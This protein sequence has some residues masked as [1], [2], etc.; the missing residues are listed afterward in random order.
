[1]ARGSYAFGLEAGGHGERELSVTRF[2]GTEALSEP[3]L[4]EVDF[5]PVSGE[6]LDLEKLIG[7]AACLTVRC[8]DGAERPFRGI[9]SAARFLGRKKGRWQ[10]RVN[11]SPRLCMLGIASRSRTFP[12]ATVPEIAKQVL[13][14][15]KITQRWEVRGSYPKREC[16]A[17]YREPDLAFLSR[18]LEQEGIWYRFEEGEGG[19]TMVVGDGGRGFAGAGRIWY[20]QKDSAAGDEEHLYELSRRTRRVPGKVVLRD[21]DFERPM[22]DLTVTAEDGKG[23]EVYEYP[24]GYTDPGD[25]RRLAR[26]RLEE[27]RFG[28]GTWGG[29][30]EEELPDELLRDRRQ[31]CLPAAAQDRPAGGARFPASDGGGPGAGGDP[32]RPTR[33]GEAGLPLERRKGRAAAVGLGAGAAVGGGAGIRGGVPAARRAGGAGELPGRRPGASDSHRGRLPR[34][35]PAR[36]GAAEGQDAEHASH[37]LVAVQRGLQRAPVRGRGRVG[38]DL[39]PRAEGQEDRGAGR[40]GPAR[41]WAGGADG[42]EGPQPGGGREPGAG[43]EGGRQRDG[44]REPDARRDWRSHDESRWRPRRGGGPCPDGDGQR[45]AGRVRG[46]DR[47]RDGR[48]RG[49]AQRGG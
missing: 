27:L 32:H 44:G 23:E 12:D 11:L 36:G 42:G 9:V 16:T 39:R 10:Y 41:R 2:V 28:A 35:A 48:S 21:Y 4:F 8:S 29:G 45:R 6:P 25:G 47:E 38:A 13:D 24:G 14:A 18:V 46:S 40:Q 3:Y 20:R 34:V 37:G 31:P 15:G 17:Q 33:T 43:G 30:G 22:L 5:F 19:C 49:G 7:T 26:V 1:M